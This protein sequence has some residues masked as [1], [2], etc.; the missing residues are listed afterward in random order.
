M[1]SNFCLVF[2]RWALLKKALKSF[3]SFLPWVKKTKKKGLIGQYLAETGYY[4]IQATKPDTVGVGLN[5]SP[6]GLAS[7]IIEKFSTG[8]NASYKYRE[9]GGF[10]E[11]YTYDELIDNLM[12]Y[13]VS[14]SM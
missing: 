1:H 9:D 10:L 14:N 8:T 2:S 5:D 13:W 4:H 6:A 11:K 12:I 3:S 7:Y